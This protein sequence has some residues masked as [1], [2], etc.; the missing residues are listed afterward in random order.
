M[1]ELALVLALL[2][3]APQEPKKV[4]LPSDE[5][6][7]KMAAAMPEAPASALKRPWKLLVVGQD[8]SHDPV[9]YCSKALELMGKKTSWFV[10][11]ITDDGASFEPEKLAEFDVVVVNS[12][13]GFDPFLGVPKKEF[14]ALPAGKKVALKE[15]ETRRRKSL[16]DFVAGGKGLV[17]IHAATVGLADWKEYYEMIGGRYIALPYLE[18][19]VKV[20]DPGHPVNAAFGGKDFRLADEFYEL[21]AP[22]SRETVRVLLSVDAGKMKDVEK[23]T[24]YGKPVRTDGDYGLSWVKSYGKGRV[25]YCALGHFSETYWN[26][27][28]LR[29][30]FDGIRFAA[31]DLQA[32]TTPTGKLK[33]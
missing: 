33:K 5:E 22:Y 24:K 17:G 12:W 30:F 2:A 27:A 4:R 29:H 7:A 3:A 21:Q 25:F 31:G 10:P 16:L 26:P 18:A 23:V 9:P 15:Q 8:A 20:D 19:A 13:H 11:V 1:R 32:D 6:I 28:M 14:D